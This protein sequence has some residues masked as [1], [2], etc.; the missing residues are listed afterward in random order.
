MRSNIESDYKSVVAEYMADLFK[1]LL[2]DRSGEHSTNHL[3]RPPSMSDR[4][5]EDAHQMCDALVTALLRPVYLSWDVEQYVQRL[6]PGITGINETLESDLRRRFPPILPGNRATYIS[7]NPVTIVDC[8]GRI[9]GWVVPNVLSRDQQIK[10]VNAA[11]CLSSNI[12]TNY[13]RHAMG[14]KASSWRGNHSYFKNPAHC[15]LIHPGYVNFSPGWYEAGHDDD[16]T[17]VPAPSPLLQSP[18]GSLWCETLTD[19]H[20]ILAGAMRIMHPQ[21]YVAASDLTNALAGVEDVHT[22]ITNWGV[23]PFNAVSVI[24]NRETPH[25]RDPGTTLRC[26]DMMISV[27]PFTSAPM[28]LEGLGIEIENTPGTL[29]VLPGK[30]T[31]ISTGEVHSGRRTKRKVAVYDTHPVEPPGPSPPPSDVEEGPSNQSFF[32]DLGAEPDHAYYGDG[33]YYSMS[34]NDFLRNW[35]PFRSVYEADILDR[36]AIP[37]ERKCMAPLLCSDC[38]RTEHIRHPFHRPDRWNGVTFLRT[39]GWQAEVGLELYVGHALGARCPVYGEEST[40]DPRFEPPP[41]GEAEDDTEEDR[42]DNAHFAE[43][44]QGYDVDEMRRPKGSDPWRNR[45]LT[46]VDITGIH[47]IRVKY[48]RCADTIPEHRQLLRAGL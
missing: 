32:H 46:I 36:E 18:A 15:T 30:T 34:Q 13:A 11:K 3:E 44:T 2:L 23:G 37:N 10:M 42:N 24:A 26:Y 5:L 17:A 9:I 19:V 12:R 8:F 40:T 33:V 45:F 39:L 38:C 41:S 14:P 28:H 43:E 4:V 47:Y 21:Q 35:L 16:A 1:C 31:R 22:A 7:N 48:C 27:G 6:G 20:A 29:I 25:H